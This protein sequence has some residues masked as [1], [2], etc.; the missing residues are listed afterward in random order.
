MLC[1]SHSDFSQHPVSTCF[2]SVFCP[3]HLVLFS[4]GTVEIKPRILFSVL[5]FKFYIIIKF[6]ELPP[7]P[8]K[9]D[10]RGIAYVTMM[11][12]KRGSQEIPN[13]VLRTPC[14]HC[15]RDN[16]LPIRASNLLAPS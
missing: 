16:D 12:F 15:E 6:V 7:E 4:L 5:F 3:I 11:Y 9:R 1:S 14:F 13:L 10:G 8:P 2:A